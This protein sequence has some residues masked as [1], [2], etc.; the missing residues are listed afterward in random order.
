M[1]PHIR[2]VF[3]VAAMLAHQVSAAMPPIS[4]NDDPLILRCMSAPPGTLK[5]SGFTMSGSHGD[6]TYAYE[7]AFDPATWSGSVKKRRIGFDQGNVPVQDAEWDAADVLSTID[8]QVRRVYMLRTDV[9]PHTVPFAWERLS[10]SQ[11]ALLDLSPVTAKS[12]GFGERRLQYLRGDRSLEAGKPHGLFRPRAR[13]LGDIVNSTPIFV[14]APSPAIQEASYQTFYQQNK[15][16]PPA[17]FVGANDGML[18]AFD[19]GA[20]FRTR[21][22]RCSRNCCGRTTHIVSMSMVRW[23]QRRRR[24]PRS[25][26]RSWLPPCE[27][28]RKAYSRWM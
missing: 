26:R 20:I 27:V 22:F 9:T 8:P 25:G 13:L 12:D 15:D 11:K 14:G 10:A 5:V 7:S 23:W 19:A 2:A 1:R 17:V 18:H 16:R 4:L 24:W 28:A 3:V 6:A 21:C